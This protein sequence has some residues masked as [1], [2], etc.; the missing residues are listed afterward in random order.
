MTNATGEM[1]EVSAGP[2]VWDIR[3]ERASLKRTILGST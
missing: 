3:E 1:A 2:P